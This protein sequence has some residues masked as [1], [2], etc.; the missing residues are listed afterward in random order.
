MPLHS[1]S[2]RAHASRPDSQQPRTAAGGRRLSRHQRSDLLD[3]SEPSDVEADVAYV[4]SSASSGP[5]SN[6]SPSSED[7]W[8][9]R[10]QA[11][12]DVS[13][14]ASTS[15]A[16]GVPEGAYRL[17]RQGNGAQRREGVPDPR[18]SGWDPE[19]GVQAAWQQ[20]GQQQGRP[21]QSVSQAGSAGGVKPWWQVTLRANQCLDERPPAGAL[22]LSTA[23]LSCVPGRF[24]P[25]AAQCQVRCPGCNMLRAPRS[26]LL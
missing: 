12:V 4:A 17:P 6:A 15:A 5:R 24:A 7:S 21:A 16:S 22:Q 25:A 19:G 2:L 18:D 3:N 1:L 11:R 13:G 23:L 14:Q 10:R 20:L 8:E 9:Q 26:L